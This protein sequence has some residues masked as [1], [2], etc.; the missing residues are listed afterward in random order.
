[1]VVK[2]TESIR[3]LLVGQTVITP[4]GPLVPP[5]G[6]PDVV[7]VIA[8][9]AVSALLDYQDA[10]YAR[11]YL[12][13]L[14]RF[15]GRRDVPVALF[16]EIAR[17]MAESMMYE[18]PIRIAQLALR[19][20]DGTERICQFRV[21][22]YVSLLPEVIAAPLLS[23]LQR[24]GCLDRKLN[25]RFNAKTTFGGRRLRIEASLRHWR[26]ISVRY[27]AERLWVARWLHMIDRALT[28]QPPAA[29]AI[30]ET[31]TMLHGYGDTYRQALADW[32][33]IIDELAK[34]TFDGVL[35]LP[36]LGEAIAHARAASDSTRPQRALKSEIARIKKGHVDIHEKNAT[37]SAPG[38]ASSLNQA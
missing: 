30:V 19:D 18:D 25:R 31:A 11:L 6:L 10:A 15:I 5:D 27:T 36:D 3:E 34:P 16:A 14:K 28:K 8:A 1:L 12:D 37:T 4:A 38:E 23:F 17:L 22:E 33:L 9:D 24:I 20:P 26:A 7:R 2:F 32:H 21:D 13:R 35:A 29:A